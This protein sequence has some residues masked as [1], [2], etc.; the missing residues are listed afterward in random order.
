MNATQQK[1]N[2]TRGFETLAEETR[3]DSL[4]V[5]GAFPEW[6]QGSL[7]RNGPAQFE[8]GARPFNHWFD[9]AAMLHRF[10]FAGG[11]V[12]YANK[13]LQTPG[14][15]G[16]RAAGK[17][18]F[19]EFATDPCRNLY[20]RVMSVF[21]Q[22]ASHNANVNLTRLAGEFIALTETPLPVAFDAETLETAG[23][24]GFADKLGFASTTAHPHFDPKR[25]VGINHLITYGRES[26]YSF[27][28][29]PDEKPLRREVMSQIKVAEP[30][31]IHSFGMTEN[32]MILAEYPLTVNP[33]KLLLSGKPFIANFTWRPERG[34]RFLVVSKEDGKLVRSHSAEAFFSF[35]HINAFEEG[36]DI[37][38][39]I[40]AFPDDQLVQQLYLKRLRS[41][42]GGDIAFPEFRRYR[43]PKDGGEATY[44]LLSEYAIELPR[45]NYRVN[46]LPYRYAYGS[47][48]N[49]EK[50]G[51]FL[52]ALV[53]VD[54]KTRESKLWFEEDCYPGEPVFVAAPGRGLGGERA[55]DEGVI[56]SVVLDGTKGTSFLLVLD[57]ANFEERAR[58]LVPHHIPFGFH[59]QY[60][61]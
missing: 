37:V 51:D 48:I 21:K 41:E 36:G 11:R 3:I 19:S 58:A 14:Y 1:A 60:F 39:D 52:N 23:V 18:S 32:Y 22:G 33:L 28:T 53:K 20:Q 9:G 10:G 56:L 31:Y 6:L 43:L 5:R 4:E 26:T 8:V 27:I 25:R 35:H 55:E 34:A 38:V 49:P 57:A 30:A 47:S 44:E 2:F 42:R 59:G 50:R 61:A 45:I 13:Y 29:I 12:S 17:I 16:N 15:L 46:G 24:A 54:V 7:I 40:S